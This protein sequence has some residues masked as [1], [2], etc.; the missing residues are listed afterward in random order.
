MTLAARLLE[1]S[2]SVARTLL[3]PPQT[4][5]GKLESRGLFTDGNGRRVV[6]RMSDSTG[7]RRVSGA[8]RDNLQH[9]EMDTI[10]CADTDDG[11][12]EIN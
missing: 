5:V 1:A 8:P 6:G 10:A 11:R 7:N 2:H 3:S 9:V 12:S 4:S